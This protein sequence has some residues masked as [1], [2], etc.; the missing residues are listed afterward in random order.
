MASKLCLCILKVVVKVLVAQ[1]CQI[2]CNPV[3]CSQQAPLSMGFPR[4][5]TGIGF[6]FLLQGIFQ[7]QGL[8]LGLL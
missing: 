4:Q 7:T 1:L 3:D 8:K 2:L 6:H 5:N